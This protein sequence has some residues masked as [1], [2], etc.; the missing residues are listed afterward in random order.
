[1]SPYSLYIIVRNFCFN[2]KN[3]YLKIIPVF[4]TSS[5]IKGYT[6]SVTLSTA[7]KM[8]TNAGAM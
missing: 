4:L 8:L 7:A 6:S 1:M 3:N 2:L 5:A